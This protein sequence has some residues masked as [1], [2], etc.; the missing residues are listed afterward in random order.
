M[1]TSWQLKVPKQLRPAQG[2]GKPAG[3]NRQRGKQ[4]SNSAALFAQIQKGY[5]LKPVNP[6]TNQKNGSSKSNVGKKGASTNFRIILEKAMEKRRLNIN[7]NN[8]QNHE[9]HETDWS[10]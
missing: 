9:L 3:N 1:P 10:E 2:P 6:P 8:K 5:S 7:P 4:Q